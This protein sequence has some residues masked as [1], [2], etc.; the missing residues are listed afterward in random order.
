[1]PSKT[2]VNFA[3]LMRSTRHELRALFVYPLPYNTFKPPS[4]ALFLSLA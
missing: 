2:L 3:H 4:P 1:M